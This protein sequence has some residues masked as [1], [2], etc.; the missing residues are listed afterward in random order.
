MDAYG[1]LIAL[2]DAHRIS[3][4]LIDHEPEGQTE[5]ASVLRGHPLFA[6]VKCIVVMA[7]LGRQVTKYVLAVIPGDA[8]LDLA[9]LK[10]LLCVGFQQPPALLDAFGG[11]G[12]AEFLRFQ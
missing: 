8:R 6:A 11:I 4:R 12:I 9:A 10:K 1:K 2:L 5:R 7:K 3:Y